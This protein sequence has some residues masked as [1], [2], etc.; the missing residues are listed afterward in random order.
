M[1]EEIIVNVIGIIKTKGLEMLNSKKK[2]SRYKAK[3]IFNDALNLSSTYLKED[4]LLLLDDISIEEKWRE[5]INKCK[6][7]IQIINASIKIKI[8]EEN[9]RNGYILYIRNANEDEEHLELVLDNYRDALRELENDEQKIDIELEAICLANIAK[10][11]Y[12]YFNH[13]NKIDFL[14]EIHEI[15]SESVRRAMALVNVSHKNVENTEWFKEIKSIDIE[16]NDFLLLEEEK[17]SGGFKLKIKKE[18]Q[19]IFNNLNK[20]FKKNNL[21]IIK[22]I[23]N[24]YPPLNYEKEPNNTIEEQWQEDKKKFVHNLCI[25]YAPD[26]YPK[27][28]EEEKLKYVIMSEISTKINSIYNE[29]K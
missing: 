12:K 26:N 1:F 15:S 20:V 28:T 27:E 21:E 14:K 6:E 5:Y 11:K 19:E 18:N 23:L 17:N 13:N 2:W 24:K 9:D 22:Y 25:K 8:K 16:I 3:M 4:D 7:S 29:I 10:I